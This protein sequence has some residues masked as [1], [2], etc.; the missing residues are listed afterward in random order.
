MSPKK[1]KALTDKAYA[2][3]SEKILNIGTQNFLRLFHTELVHLVVF[4]CAEFNDKQYGYS[5]GAELL[6]HFEIKEKA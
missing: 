1:I 2:N 6:E 4:E 3:A 5:A